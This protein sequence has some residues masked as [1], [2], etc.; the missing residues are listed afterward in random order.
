VARV[1]SVSLR[2]NLV[3]V[4]HRSPSHY[5][6][7]A[8]FSAFSSLGKAQLVWH[9]APDATNCCTDCCKALNVKLFCEARMSDRP[10]IS[11]DFGAAFSLDHAWITHEV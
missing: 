7:K 3:G 4:E 1:L 10:K 9:L 11:A 6:E 5:A 2:H 8:R